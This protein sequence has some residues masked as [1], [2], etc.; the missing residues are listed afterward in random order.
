MKIILIIRQEEAP[1]IKFII[2]KIIYTSKYSV[3]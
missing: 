2:K 1:I 3:I